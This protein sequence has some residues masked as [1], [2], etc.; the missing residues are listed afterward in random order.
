MSYKYLDTETT[1][2]DFCQQI[3]NKAT[4]F[5]I[6]TEFMRT[7]TFYAELSLIQIYSEQGDAA[8]ID[9]IA[10][11]DLTPLWSLLSN[12][13]ILKVFHSARQDIEILY[14]VAGQMPVSIFDTQVAGLF[15][16]HGDLAGLARVLKAELNIDIPKDQSRTNWNQRPLT[17]KQ[18]DY[19]INDVK[20]LAPLYEKIMSKLTAPQLEALKEDFNGFLNEDLYDGNPLKTTERIKKASQ[21]APKNR[22]ISDALA[23]WREDYAIKK[24]KPRKWSISDDCILAIAQRPPKTVEALYKVPNIKASSIK[25]FGETWIALIDEVFEQPNNWPKKIESSFSPTEQEQ[26]FLSIAQ[27]ITQQLAIDYG[28]NINNIANKQTQLEMIR[29][30]DSK[31]QTGWRHFLMELPFKALIHSEKNLQIKPTLVIE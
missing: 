14:Q 17:A 21:L 15:L 28:L 29:K 10:I 7:N 27:A 2:A 26:V 19:A 18:L 3:A 25:E 13:N 24:N 9:P 8:I 5:A 23:L 20:F 30:I 16:G 31:Q 6:D 22:A 1:L 11:K 4:W 12:P